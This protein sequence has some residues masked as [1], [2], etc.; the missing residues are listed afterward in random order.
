[1]ETPG[2]SEILPP[3]TME[4]DLVQHSWLSLLMLGLVL[5]T[6]KLKVGYVLASRKAPSLPTGQ[7][8]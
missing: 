5:D 1:M 7:E 3:L 8:D 2:I 6:V 4:V